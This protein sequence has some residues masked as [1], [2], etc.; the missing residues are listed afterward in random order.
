MSIHSYVILPFWY[1]FIFKITKKF[2]ILLFL[3]KITCFLLKNRSY[4]CVLTSLFSAGREGTDKGEGVHPR[5]V[6]CIWAVCYN[7][8]TNGEQPPSGLPYPF[9]SLTNKYRQVHQFIIFLPLQS[10]E[11]E[12]IMFEFA[13]ENYVNKTNWKQDCRYRSA[14]S[15]RSGGV[16]MSAKPERPY[17]NRQ[18]MPIVGEL[19]GLKRNPIKFRVIY[20]WNKDFTNGTITAFELFGA[21]KRDKNSLFVNGDITKMVQNVVEFVKTEA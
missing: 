4:I 16:S 21:T 12:K 9:R 20:T 17:F 19:R 3:L 1:S 11:A 14:R 15:E 18:N 10:G 5:A 7:V 8:G 2:F 13:N 6:C